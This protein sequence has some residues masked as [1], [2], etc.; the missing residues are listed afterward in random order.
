M[1]NSILE[2][3]T[4]HLKQSLYLSKH[5]QLILESIK[6]VED[7]DYILLKEYSDAK[8]EAISNYSTI[9]YADAL[10]VARVLFIG[11]NYV[12]KAAESFDCIALLRYERNNL[13]LNFAKVDRKSMLKEDPYIYRTL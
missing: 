9:S 11:P 5:R 12:K 7:K 1:P 2:E 13:P 4:E 3:Y 6:K 8:K 10:K